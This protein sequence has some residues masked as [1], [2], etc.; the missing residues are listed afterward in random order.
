MSLVS[1]NGGEYLDVTK[2]NFLGETKV[3]AYVVRA[4]PG[5]DVTGQNFI[6]F[7]LRD[8]NGSVIW[9][10][11]FRVGNFNT[12]GYDILELN[13]RVIEIS[14]TAD[15]KF[16][17]ASMKIM[18][19]SV[20]DDPSDLTK[21]MSKYEGAGADYERYKNT[22]SSHGVN[23]SLSAEVLSSIVLS[24]GNGSV[25]MYM[26]FC[27]TVLDSI[28]PYLSMPGIIASDLLEVLD[29]TLE[30]YRKD[31]MVRE[32]GLVRLKFASMQATADGSKLSA[33]PSVRNIT[34]D[35]LDALIRDHKPEHLYSHIVVKNVRTALNL[36]SLI[37]SYATVFPGHGVE[38]GDEIL[39]KY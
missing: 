27:S 24:I 16:G 30:A 39:A 34:A 2:I 28:T 1:K 12:I 31:L 35:C 14:Y 9:A 29:L 37:N 10:I 3:K 15:N 32:K 6:S 13:R 23:P 11:M 7:L 33:N 20:S 4:K 22:M 18:N 36:F 26:K 21:F 5:V 25:G 17:G 19:L 8:I 38:V